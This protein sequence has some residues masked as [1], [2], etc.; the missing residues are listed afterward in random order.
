MVEM[1]AR[2]SSRGNGQAKQGATTRMDNPK[3][4]QLLRLLADILAMPRKQDRKETPPKQHNSS[5]AP[6]EKR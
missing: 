1:V 2:P 4:L 3:Y 6:Q 5:P